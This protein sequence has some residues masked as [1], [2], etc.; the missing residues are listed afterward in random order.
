[1]IKLNGMV[2][3]ANYFPD[4]TQLLKIEQ[5]LLSGDRIQCMWQY[6]KEEEL[7][8]I[9]YLTRHF[10]SKGLVVSLVM[11][12]IPNARMDRVKQDTEVFTLKYFAE[13]INQMKFASVTVLD[14]HSNVSTALIDRIKIMSPRKYIETAINEI[15]TKTGD[16]ILYF[17]DEGAAKRYSELFQRPYC[18]GI[19]KRNWE[20]GAILGIDVMSNGIDL[21]G[22]NILMIDDIIAYGGSLYYSAKCL[23]EL[24]CGEIYAYATHI[25]KSILDKGQGKLLQSGLVE[26][27]Y[28]TDS[29]FLE[30]H[31]K[32][33]VLYIEE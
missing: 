21:A 2:Y 9:M 10:Q 15:E 8:T 6:E 29:L 22:K 14:P 4:G 7:L 33:T 24:K 3:E 19:K 25:E 31:E 12:Y 32:I 13:I 17:P 23:K 1:M 16:V 26:Q 11:P 28:T 20:D 27:I 30:K 5:K 18:Y